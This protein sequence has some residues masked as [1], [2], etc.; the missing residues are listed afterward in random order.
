MALHVPA[1]FFLVL[2]IFCI[3]CGALLL[4]LVGGF[5]LIL[6]G[7]GV[8]NVTFRDVLDVYGRSGIAKYLP[9]NVFHYVGRNVLARRFKWSQI[10]VAV[11][12]AL[13]IA[14]MRRCASNVFL[15]VSC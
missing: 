12:S 1:P 11:S 15:A 9:G 6:A 8:Q 4:L 3:A 7:T 10:A 5:A 14:R 2:A 13:E